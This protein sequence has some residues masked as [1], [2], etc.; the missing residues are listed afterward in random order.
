M[1]MLVKFRETI[2]EFGIMVNPCCS[3]VKILNDKV[4]RFSTQGPIEETLPILSKPQ[5]ENVSE[6][7][8]RSDLMV[9][10]IPCSLEVD[11]VP[12]DSLEETS[13]TTPDDSPLESTDEMNCAEIKHILPFVH[14][15]DLVCAYNKLGLNANLYEFFY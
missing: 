11:N 4:A 13:K 15:P 8:Q 9:K 5:S 10:E 2:I 12:G 14:T 7:S 1:L 6:T 3:S